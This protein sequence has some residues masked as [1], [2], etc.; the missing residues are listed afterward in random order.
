VNSGNQFILVMERC[1]VFFE[2]RTEMLH[3]TSTNFG[4]KGLS[5]VPYKNF[6]VRIFRNTAG[7]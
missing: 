2:V 1:Y 3:I 6:A 4:C 7:I 5:M